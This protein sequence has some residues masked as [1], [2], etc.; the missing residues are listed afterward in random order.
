MNTSST[1][2]TTGNRFYGLRT[3]A[4]YQGLVA[5]G[6][7]LAISL[8]TAGSASAQY[9]RRTYARTDIER[10]IRA[11][12]Q[13]AQDFQRD[14]DTRLDRSRIDG[15]P[16]EDTYNRQVQ[17]LTSALS[18]LRSNFNSRNDWWLARSDM[19][20][21][22]SAATSVN[23]IMSSRQVRGG[24]GLNRQWT[25]LR[26]NLDQLATAFNLPPVGTNF[27]GIP[28]YPQYGGNARNCTATGTYRGYTNTGES[29]LTIARDGT[30]TLRPL[31]SSYVYSGRCANDVVYF[32]WGAFNLVR[33]GRNLTI[34]EVGN[35]GNRTSFRRTSGGG[36]LGDV[37]ETYPGQ[38]YGNVPSWAVGVFRGMTNDGEAELTIRP[39][40]VATA[41]S[42]IN[43]NVFNGR[44]ANDLLTFDWGSFRLVNEG[45]GIRAVEVGKRT[46]IL[47][48]RVS[49]YTGDTGTYVPTYPGQQT[50]NLPSWAIGR[51]RGMT[52]DG[53]AEITITADGLATARSL[54]NNAVFN[55]RFANDLLTFD[56]G[57]FRLV[58]ERSGISLVEVGKSSGI[59]YRRVD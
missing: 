7:I 51:F 59:Y 47:Y 37:V 34:V 13:S 1:K 46:G 12:E 57:S 11:V 29:E 40:G 16:Q 39:D 15:R 23:S 24:G 32:E 31:N 26:Q 5:L 30:A 2:H 25:V 8:G 38:N 44:Y 9:Q 54:T 18:S 19:Q 58:R 28:T 55:G 17:N 42:L 3:T 20:R 27:A 33:D 36:R 43:N 49:D 10:F 22:L 48:R 14:F 45:G 53:E 52:N 35:Q 56:W 50:A 41:R 6:F 21:V 4:L